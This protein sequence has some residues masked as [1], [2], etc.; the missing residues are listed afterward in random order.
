MRIVPLIHAAGDF[1]LA[2]RHGDAVD[3][4]ARD[5]DSLALW[6]DLIKKDARASAFS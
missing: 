2:P 6:T 5:R 1:A 3:R 4:L